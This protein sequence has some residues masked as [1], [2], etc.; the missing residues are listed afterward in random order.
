MSK[1]SQVEKD[2]DQ[3]SAGYESMDMETA[4]LIEHHVADALSRVDRIAKTERTEYSDEKRAFL[5]RRK[6]TLADARQDARL[7]AVALRKAYE[8]VDPSKPPYS[9]PFTTDVP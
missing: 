9:P 4:G 1:P 3:E 8:L 6:Y 7:A 5:R 2:V